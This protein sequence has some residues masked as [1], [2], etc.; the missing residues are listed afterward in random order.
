MKNSNKD[1]NKVA[2][3]IKKVT[4]SL[5]KEKKEA[6]KLVA[7]SSE[8]GGSMTK[9]MN[10][11]MSFTPSK[12]QSSFKSYFQ[13][14]PG[15]N[16][17]SRC[18]GADYIGLAS[19][20][21]GST[22]G[23]VLNINGVQ[24]NIPISPLTAFFLNTRLYTE[25]LRFEKYRFRKMRF[26][27]CPDVGTST[28]GSII[29]AFDPDPADNLLNMN[30]G[31]ADQS[32]ASVQILMG[33]QD[34]MKSSVWTPSILECKTIKSDPQNFYYTNY[35][36]GDIRLAAQGQLWVANGGSLPS[37]TSLGAIAIEYE[38]E[39]FDP[40][41]DQLLSQAAFTKT[42]ATSLNQNAAFNTITITPTSNFSGGGK[43]L[44]PLGTDSLSNVFVAMPPGVHEVITANTCSSGGT[45]TPPKVSLSFLDNIGQAITTVATLIT[46]L[47]SSAAATSSST[48]RYKVVVPP[49]GTKMYGLFDPA[50]TG[51]TASM[52][53]QATQWAASAL[54]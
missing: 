20:A 32:L 17:S 49:G 3:E 26:L 6:K 45:P 19:T 44:Y 8:S 36:G 5:K 35:S 11:G 27:F 14:I 54:L 33:F 48:R 7:S 43:Q 21:G 22:Q 52:L 41:L 12:I 15:K 29:M 13:S 9:A 37:N 40:S 24:G 39:F 30:P 10:F 2:K 18:V 38:I 53:L 42:G 1:L 47:N 28:N 46:D 34:S 16:G 4:K 23:T 31:T 51:T 50:F 25:A